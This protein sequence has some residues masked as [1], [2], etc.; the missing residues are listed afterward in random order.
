MRFQAAAEEAMAVAEMVVAVTVA[1]VTVAMAAVA[2]IE[3]LVTRV[4]YW[5]P[6]LSQKCPSLF[7]NFWENFIENF[8]KKFPSI[9]TPLVPSD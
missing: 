7:Q 9:L 6:G 8:E 5:L 3:S 4:K 1:A 2:D